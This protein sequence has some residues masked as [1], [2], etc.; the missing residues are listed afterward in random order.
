MRPLLATAL[1]LVILFAF[2]PLALGQGQPAPDP[3]TVAPGEPAERPVGKA[4]AQEALSILAQESGAPAISSRKPVRD[5][6]AVTAKAAP[7]ADAAPGAQAAQEPEPPS[8]EPQPGAPGE[9]DDPDEPVV[10][11]GTPQGGTGAGTLP[12]TGLD[13]LWFALG[14]IALLLAGW[15]LHLFTRI[16]EV[17]RRLRTPREALREELEGLLEAGAE[18]ERAYAA[19]KPDPPVEPATPGAQRMSRRD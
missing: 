9:P 19:A 4:M 8:G 6:Y 2:A 17:I 10:P 16:R 1:A 5:R 15:R 3:Y 18:Q 7:P 14:G 12:R 11:G 13:A